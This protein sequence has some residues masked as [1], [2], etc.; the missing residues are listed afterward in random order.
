MKVI[1]MGEIEPVDDTCGPVRPVWG[2]SQADMAR[3]T[4]R[5][6]ASTEAHH[7]KVMTEV[8]TI[9]SGE[10]RLIMDGEAVEVRTGDLIEIPVGVIHQLINTGSTELELGILC[11]PPFD[12]T[13][14]YLQ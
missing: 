14:I 9:E 8:Y 12:P 6:G 10:G 11:I 5:V 13:D 2:N 3:L 1:K 7:H 4:M